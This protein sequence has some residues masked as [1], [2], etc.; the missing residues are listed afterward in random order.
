M[1][2]PLIYLLY[3][4]A[5]FG[6]FGLLFLF[7]NV[8]HLSKFGLENVKTY[9]IITLYLGVFLGLI[10]VSLIALAT[11]DWSREIDLKALFLD[12]IGTNKIVSIPR[13]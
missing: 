6:L 13:L 2:F 3:A 8:Y 10:A 9:F 11:I 1:I 7:F 4:Y 5:F 12:I